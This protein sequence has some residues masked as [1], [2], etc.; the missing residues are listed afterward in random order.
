VVPLSKPTVNNNA[1]FVVATRHDNI[2]I[3]IH[4]LMFVAT[5][6]RQHICVQQDL[7]Q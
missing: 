7:F 3:L 2:F 1:I 5:G 6:A 4:G